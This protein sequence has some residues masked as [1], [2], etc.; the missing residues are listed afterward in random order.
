MKPIDI[1]ELD[2]LINFF[3]RNKFNLVLPLDPWSKNAWNWR[4]RYNSGCACV[5]LFPYYR[6]N[7]L[8]LERQE[9]ILIT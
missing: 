2:D 3:F 8:S 6:I 4:N 5:L 1:L 7:L 9:E